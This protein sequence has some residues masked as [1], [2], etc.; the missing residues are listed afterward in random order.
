VKATNPVLQAVFLF[1]QISASTQIFPVPVQQKKF[2]NTG[3]ETIGKKKKG[4]TRVCQV[5]K[6][7]SG[8][9]MIKIFHKLNQ[10]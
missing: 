2:H 7:T 1:H 6:Q 8:E 4:S 3:V 10:I 5:K 9:M